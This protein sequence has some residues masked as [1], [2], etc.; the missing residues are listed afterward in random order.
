M[1][2]VT[3][4]IRIDPETRNR[5]KGLAALN[6]ESMQSLIEK[7]IVDYIENNDVKPSNKGA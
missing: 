3:I 6:N 5:F 7:F 2:T 1:K 4:P